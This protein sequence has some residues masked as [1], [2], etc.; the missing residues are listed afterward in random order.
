MLAHDDTN[1]AGELR[2][3]ALVFSTSVLRWTKTVDLRVADGNV[4]LALS[5][6]GGTDAVAVSARSGLPLDEVYP[7][8]HRLT[9]RGF[10]LEEHR[11]H[12]L[13]AEGHRL[14]A[15]FDLN[16]QAKGTP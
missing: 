1:L 6:T 8:L 7:S 15:E 11:R 12:M 2:H 16:A 9:D 4:L 3:T 10:V 14:V 13:T 5:E